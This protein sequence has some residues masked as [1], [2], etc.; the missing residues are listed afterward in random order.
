MFTGIVEELGT[1]KSI[2]ANSQGLDILISADKIFDDLKVG[3][4]VA[5]NGCCQTVTSLWNKEFTVQ[6]VNETVKLT[7]FKSLKYGE[8]VN[9]ERAATPTSRLGGHIVSGHIDGVGKVVSVE[10]AGNSTIF[11]F[12]APVNIMK[13]LI[14]KGSVAIDGVSLTICDINDST[15]KVSVI[16]HTL[17]NTTFGSLQVGSEVNLEPDM[18]AKYVEKML[19]KDE[20]PQQAGGITMEFLEENGF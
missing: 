6:A 11:E 2:R 16:P 15:F 3:D 7:A 20:T 12:S 9:L 18:I 10:K 4:S 17:R 19:E 13:Y 14:Y 8:K 1:I 5:I